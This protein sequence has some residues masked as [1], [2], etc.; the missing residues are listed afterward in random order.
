MIFQQNSFQKPIFLDNDGGIDDLVALL[1]LLTLDQYR[2]TGVAVTNGVSPIEKSS[3]AIAKLFSLFCR[4]DLQLAKSTVKPVHPFPEKWRKSIDVFL[5]DEI[6]QQ[7]AK[8]ENQITNQDTLEFMASK[9]LNEAQQT[10]LIATGPATNL[11]Q[12]FTKYP[13]A[14][15]KIE[16]IIWMAGTIH[17]K[18]NVQENGVLQRKEWNIYWDAESANQ[19]LNSSIPILLIPI[20]TVEQ[21]TINIDLLNELKQLDSTLGKL[22]SNIFSQMYARHSKY[23]F[24]DVLTAAALLDENIFTSKKHSSVEILQDQMHYGEFNATSTG[25]NISYPNVINIE[26]F[27]EKFLN[28]LKQF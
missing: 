7:Q 27:K 1:I 11:N 10:T 23:Y 22:V 9:I 26:L 16:R 3:E 25:L 18:G 15:S 8:S 2:L 20:D 28:S 4:Y 21:A 13:E 24:W 12:F 6:I 14:T 5:N 19:L 17:K